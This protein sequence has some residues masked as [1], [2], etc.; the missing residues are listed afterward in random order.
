MNT[1][2][3]FSP[4][5]NVRYIAKE[6]SQHLDSNTELFPLEF[7]DPETLIQKDQLVILFSI[8][9]FN[10]PR[11]VKRFVKK[12]PEG[13]YKNVSLISVGC[14]DGLVNKAATWGL[15]KILEKK[16]CSILVDEIMA[17]PLSFIMSFPEEL[18]RKQ[19]AA[20]NEKI[21]LIAESILKGKK[22]E[23]KIPIRSKL[24]YFIGKVEGPAARSFGLDLYAGKACT[25]CGIC[26]K[27]CPEQNIHFNKKKKPRFGLKCLMCMRCIYICPEKAIKP[28]IFR[29]IPI[30]NGY[31]IS[32]YLKTEDDEEL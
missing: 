1:I 14:N 12:I 25:S 30:K 13:L 10:A 8:H 21:K 24:L 28:R 27:N 26:V 23:V 31:S 19:I 7:T 29:F 32:D 6:L 15:R 9:A 20:A 22:S 3:Y 5:G 16:G 17:M 2:L 11:T 18:I 4:T